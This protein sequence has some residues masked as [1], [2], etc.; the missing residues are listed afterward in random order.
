VVFAGSVYGN[1]DS[2]T[3]PQAGAVGVKSTFTAAAAPTT[4]ILA[5]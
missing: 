1:L 2:A 4:D 5:V 3:F